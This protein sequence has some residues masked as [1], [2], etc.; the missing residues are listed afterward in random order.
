[1]TAAEGLNMTRLEPLDCMFSR[2]VFRVS[3]L[4][5]WAWWHHF[6]LF[7]KCFCCEVFHF[8]T[9]R[10]WLEFVQESSVW[11]DPKMTSSKFSD[12]VLRSFLT[13]FRMLETETVQ[14][15]IKCTKT[16]VDSQGYVRAN[17]S[18]LRRTKVNTAENRNVQPAAR[19]SSWVQ[20]SRRCLHRN[21][22]S[23]TKMPPF[24]LISPRWHLRCSRLGGAREGHQRTT[25]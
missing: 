6:L 11:I 13:R 16:M 18:T 15:W 9:W 21:G 14:N 10:N 17:V 22:G 1:M 5:W 19:L 4:S 20:P 24:L 8:E 23:S 12:P 25:L 7:G 3:V 2:F